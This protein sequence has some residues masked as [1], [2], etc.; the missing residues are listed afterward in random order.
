MDRENQFVVNYKNITI[1][2][3]DG[4]LITG[5][6]NILSYNRLSEYLKQGTDK[7]ITIV[8][9]K[10]EESNSK[11]TIVNRDYIIWANTWD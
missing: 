7:F 6:I 5:K 2:T 10:S 1:K 4:S 3:T 8:S 11:I 9:E